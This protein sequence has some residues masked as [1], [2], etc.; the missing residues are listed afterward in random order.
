M[1][2][3]PRASK[4]HQCVIGLDNVSKI[5]LK[6]IIRTIGKFGVRLQIKALCQYQ[7]F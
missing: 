6:D 1:H 3:F 2:L 4:E 7:I 5:A